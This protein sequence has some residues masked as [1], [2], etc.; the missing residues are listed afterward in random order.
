[1]WG[2]SGYLSCISAALACLVGR[3]CRPMPWTTAGCGF[4]R[5]QSGP[6]VRGARAYP[7]GARSPL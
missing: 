6:G 4:L 1:M 5:S 3:I 7:P 2:G